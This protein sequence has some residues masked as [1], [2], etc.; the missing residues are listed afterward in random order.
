MDKISILAL[1]LIVSSIDADSLFIHNG[2]TGIIKSTGKFLSSLFT[3]T[4]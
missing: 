3:N 1:L 4:K 2:W